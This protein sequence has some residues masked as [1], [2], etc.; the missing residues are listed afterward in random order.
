MLPNSSPNSSL[1][2]KLRETC[3]LWRKRNL[4]VF[5]AAFAAGCLIHFPVYGNG[6]RNPDTLWN[7]E[8]Y[9][10]SY[11]E[12]S[13]GR[14]G[15]PLFDH[16]R[17]GVNASVPNALAMLI[18]F[19]L[20]GILLA[21][22]LKIE[23]RIGRF[24]AC[25]AILVTP[26]VS[27]T[28][29]YHYAAAAYGLAFFLAILAV[30]LTQRLPGW[31]GPILGALSLL[32]SLSLYQSNL[33]V[34]A[35]VCLVLLLIQ[36]ITQPDVLKKAGRLLI[37]FLLLGGLGVGGYYG[38]LQIALKANRISMS[39]Y[40][41]ASGIGISHILNRLPASIRNA[42]VDFF[43]YFFGRTIAANHYGIRLF[44][45][46]LFVCGAIA[47]LCLIGRIRRYPAAAAASVLILAALP[48]AANLI[49]TAAPDT[50]VVLLT[51]GG[52]LPVVPYVI[53]CVNQFA[54]Q[55]TAKKKIFWWLAC[56]LTGGLLWCS[57]LQISANAV[58]MQ[59]VQSQTVQLANRICCRLEEN[60][61]YNAGV[62]VMI[63]GRYGKSVDSNTTALAAKT[64]YY[65]TWG[66]TWS[67]EQGNLN[68][69]MQIFRQY[70][71]VVPNWC[72]LDQFTEIVNSDQFAAMPDYPSA[73]AVQT[74][75]GILVV[76][77][78]DLQP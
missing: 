41:G 19:T 53:A 25:A 13:L 78:S 46:L 36:V 68:G 2:Y 35:G 38:I 28:A 64:D 32:A 39:A 54:R 59:S 9:L 8:E 77:V 37:K 47:F 51:A 26:C 65:A 3:S 7:G 73:G 72:S 67:T 76:K 56:A 69:W 14:W 12:V 74:I 62:P 66:L 15:L 61:D 16:L 18:F 40:K 4:G 42:Y 29:T 71:G 50:S 60:D 55:G 75:N 63:A 20:A 52:M 24:L 34:T 33:G 48:L 58:V 30:Y 10:A 1:E 49:D 23:S 70:L 57:A 6:L 17:G 5:L 31:Y 27:L 21:D 43:R 45:G 22:L 44:Y 11:W